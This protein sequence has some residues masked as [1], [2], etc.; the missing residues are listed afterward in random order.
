MTEQEELEQIKS[1]LEEML[2]PIVV[3][4]PA[5]YD[6][7]DIVAFVIKKVEIIDI[8]DQDVKRP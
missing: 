7:E 2:S 6:P 8:K 5:N 3:K 4:D 1:L